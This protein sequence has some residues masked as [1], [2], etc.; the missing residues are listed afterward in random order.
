MPMMQC[1]HVS[2]AVCSAKGGVKFDPPIPVCA[3]CDC[4]KIAEEPDLTGRM[5]TCYCGSKSLRPSSTDLAFFEY[6][7]PGS[8]H[9]TNICKCGYTK[10]AHEKDHVQTVCKKLHEQGF[11][12]RGPHKYDSYYCGCRGWD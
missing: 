12:P 8:P 3:I 2:Q 1:G 9:A 4:F 7:G 6:R 11:T 10:K 5:A